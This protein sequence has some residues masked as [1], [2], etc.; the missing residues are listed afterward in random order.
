MCPRPDAAQDRVDHK[1]HRPGLYTG[2]CAGPSN[3]VSN[4]SH[5]R[6]Q[7][8]CCGTAP[9]PQ[10]LNM[11][12]WAWGHQWTLMLLISN[13]LTLKFAG[14]EI[15]CSVIYVRQESKALQFYKV[16]AFLNYLHLICS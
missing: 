15:M 7:G 14:S 2:T 6:C 1:A 5:C 8:P 4:K 16:V 11:M 12:A 9:H 3:T 10:T 13:A